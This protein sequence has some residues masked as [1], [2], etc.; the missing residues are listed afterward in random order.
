MRDIHIGTEID[1]RM[2]HLHMTK[3][4]FAQRLGIPKQNVNRIINSKYI[5]TDRLLTIC[6]ILNFDFF[7]L[8][9]DG[10][11]NNIHLV[12]NDDSTI[13]AFNHDVNISDCAVLQERIR[14]LE[15][16]LLEKERLIQVLLH[17]G[18]ADIK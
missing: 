9:Q 1:H 3:A 11:N 14:S 15:N 5:M 13:T 6:D 2:K 16:L 10:A 17:G 7:S 4:E 8:Y 18:H 12:A